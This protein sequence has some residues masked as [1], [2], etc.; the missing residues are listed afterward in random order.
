[1][2]TILIVDDSRTIRNQMEAMLSGANYRV[3]EAEDGKTALATLN[4]HKEIKLVFCDVNMPEMSGFEMLKAL[5]DSGN[6]TPFVL[7]STESSHEF[8]GR[9]KTLGANGYLVKP[10]SEDNVMMMIERFVNEAES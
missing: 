5:R 6:T 8:I 4:Q 9:A 7:L 2:E 10:A 3:L 1:M